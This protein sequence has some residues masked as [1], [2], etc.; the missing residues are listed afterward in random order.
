MPNSVAANSTNWHCTPVP[1]TKSS[2]SQVAVV[3][4]EP[5]VVGVRVLVEVVG[6][7]GRGA[8]LDGVHGR[9]LGK[10][11]LCQAGAV[12]AGDGCDECGPGDVRSGE[13][14]EGGRRRRAMLSGEFAGIA[15]AWAPV[16]S[17]LG[18]HYGGRFEQDSF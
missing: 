8:A 12:L 7:E 6:V 17:G 14:W 5:Y 9:P 4:R 1:T 15:N 16:A 13:I 2:V 10:Q 18:L 3:Q 11:Q